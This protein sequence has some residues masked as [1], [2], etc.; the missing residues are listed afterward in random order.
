[1]AFLS[2]CP[3]STSSWPKL[4]AP[5]ACAPEEPAEAGGLP[6]AAPRACLSVRCSRMSRACWSCIFSM[7]ARSSFVTLPSAAAFFSAASMR[8]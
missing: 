2:S 6:A 3:M 4:A 7:R 1:M 8:A 5:D